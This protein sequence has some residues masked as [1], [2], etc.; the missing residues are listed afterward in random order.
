VRRRAES[1][2]ASAIDLIYVK[3]MHD[4]CAVLADAAQGNE[5][6]TIELM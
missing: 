4:K 6:D 3:E 2:F 1:L 5:I